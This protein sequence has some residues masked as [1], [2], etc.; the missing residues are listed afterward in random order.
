MGARTAGHRSGGSAAAQA[1][2]TGVLGVDVGGTSVKAGGFDAEMRPLL[3]ERVPTRRQGG[4]DAVVD[5]VGK[6]IERMRGEM[7]RGGHEVAAVGVVVPGTVDEAHGVAVHAANLGWRDLPLRQVLED[8]VGLPV[9]LGHDVRAGGLAEGG[10]GAARGVDEF[11]FLAI[12]TGIAAAMTIGGKA[13]LRPY[14]GEIGHMLIVPGG[15]PCACGSRGCLETIASA[16]AIAARYEA[17]TGARATAGEVARRAAAGEPEAVAVW[18]EAVDALAQAVAAYT[19]LLAPE[20]VVVGGG[21]A[22]AGAQL[23]D[24]LGLAIR[25][26]LSFQPPPR[27]L[28]AELGDRA[29][30]VG[31]AELAWTRAHRPVESAL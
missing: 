26:R 30:C 9:A 24:P 31:A 22:A 8:R 12:G 10:R 20:L 4:P 23:L 21:L 6:L 5:R 11:L 2:A 25:R 14:T 15:R 17:R 3:G 13:C 27:V 16:A 19:T 29:G 28:A 7:E 18:Q 1:G